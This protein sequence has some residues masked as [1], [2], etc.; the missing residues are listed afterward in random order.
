MN[1]ERVIYFLL[2]FILS[3]SVLNWF[4]D[5][6]MILHSASFIPVDPVDEFYKNLF[7][8]NPQ[9][10]LGVPTKD[11]V[12]IFLTGSWALL[13]K[14][15]LDILAI[16]E[17]FFLLNLLLAGVC[18]YY[19][20]CT[21]DLDKKFQERAALFASLFYMFNIYVAVK[22]VYMMVFI[23]YWVMPLL[24]AMNIKYLNSHFKLKYAILFSLASLLAVPVAAN[25]P[26]YAVVCMVPFLYTLW[27]IICDFLS[28]R[29]FSFQKIFYAFMPFI[30]ALFVNFW[31]VFPFLTNVAYGLGGKGVFYQSIKRFSQESSFANLFSFFGHWALTTGHRGDKYYPIAFYYQQWYMVAFTYLAVVLSLC[32]LFFKKMTKNKL[33]FAWLLLIALFIAKAIHPPLGWLNMLFYKKLPFYRVFMNQWQKL[34]PAIILCISVFLG[35]IL[36]DLLGLMYKHNFKKYFYQCLLI[37]L[38]LTSI[39]LEA[40]P[41]LTGRHIREKQRYLKS[42]RARIPDYWFQ[43]SEWLEKNAGDSRIMLLPFNRFSS[44]AGEYKWDY[45]G[46]DVAY[47][48]IHRELIANDRHVSDSYQGVNSSYIS[49]QL[50]ANLL[51]K[52][53]LPKKLMNLLN[54]KYILQRNDFDLDFRQA[55]LKN[56]SPEQIRSVLSSMDYIRL[57]RK[58][59]QLEIYEFI[60]E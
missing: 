49:N 3:L 26:H 56:N 22:I 18:M 13:S 24:L 12:K 35:Y 30:M 53:R 59:G 28:N 50:Y 7:A 57:V 60:D 21:L 33:F 1:R 38:L 43:A 15:G 9:V 52:K 36:S 17:M 51:N 55:K 37:F 6:R 32:S 40:W 27:S 39:I 45:A 19:L 48:L 5:N 44:T 31:W 14:I 4:P 34:M 2:I 47:L 23:S 58:F 20:V 46:I 42:Y 11:F 25:P 41:I 54:I 16:E 8:W 29:K 10:R